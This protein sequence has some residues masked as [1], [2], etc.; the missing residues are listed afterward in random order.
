MAESTIMAHIDL[1]W[2]G[3][4][5]FRGVFSSAKNTHDVVEEKLL[6]M[7]PLGCVMLL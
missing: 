4:A 5:P 6:I 1:L 3:N 7:L 2:L